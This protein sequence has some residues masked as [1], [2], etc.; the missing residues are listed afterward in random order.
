MQS[1]TKRKS[2]PTHLCETDRP[3]RKQLKIGESPEMLSL[4]N[5]NK[6]LSQA[7]VD[8]MDLDFAIDGLLPFRFVSPPSFN[9]IIKAI[10]PKSNVISESTLK[11]RYGD[12][13]TTI[14]CNI[15][16][17]LNDVSYVATTTDGWSSRG[18]SFVGVTAHWIGPN[19][20]ERFWAALSY[21]RLQGSQTY[22][23]LAGALS[24]THIK[25]GITKKVVSTTTD[26]AFNF[27]KAFRIFGLV[28]EE[29]S[30]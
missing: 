27:V 14:L 16:S 5:Y 1:S 15:K 23:A 17:L 4:A 19:T 8:R 22:D 6:R 21:E 2:G 13:A 10:S 11:R 30:R 26:N 20:I 25:F 24:S 7:D 28:D 12:L 9:R 18:R 3:F 29:L